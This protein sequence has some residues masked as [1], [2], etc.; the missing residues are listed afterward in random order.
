M[1]VCPQ[2]I[3]TERSGNHIFR[4]TGPGADQDPKGLFTIDV[5]TGEVSVSRS[6]DRE[7]TDSYQVSVCV[8]VCRLCV[9]GTLSLSDS[10]RLLLCSLSVLVLFCLQIVS[11]SAQVLQI[12]FKV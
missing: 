7:A 11:A 1:F 4:L 5:D 8:C 6:L 3:S 10:L 9:L 12:K 2:V